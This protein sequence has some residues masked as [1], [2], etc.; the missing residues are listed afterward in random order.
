MPDLCSVSRFCSTLLGARTKAINEHNEGT[1][2][3]SVPDGNFRLNFSR[4]TVGRGDKG[5]KYERMLWH[6]DLLTPVC[7][8][9]RVP[10][11]T[12]RTNGFDLLQCAGRGHDLSSSRQQSAQETYF[13]HSLVIGPS[14][15]QVKEE[16]GTKSVCSRRET[17][18][19]KRQGFM[20]HSLL[21]SASGCFPPCQWDL[22][23]QYRYCI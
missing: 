10:N 14:T 12:S 17:L 5:K 6:V 15:Q 22:P 9:A 20:Q 4:R 7:R 3:K 21:L 11:Q 13:S 2:K 16:S 19:D 1:P 23:K 8:F 18:Q